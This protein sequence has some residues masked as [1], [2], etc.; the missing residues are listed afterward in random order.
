MAHEIEFRSGKYSFVENGKHELSWHN[1]GTVYDRP[2][3]A[4]E[5]LIGCRAD[6]VV[7]SRK[8]TSLTEEQLIK[9][10]SG[11]PIIILPEQISDSHRAITRKDTNKILSVASDRYSI[12]QNTKAFEFVDYL[13]TGELGAKASID[14]AGVLMDGKKIFITAKFDEQVKIPGSN[15]DIMDFYL[16]FTNGFDKQSPV[17]C[18]TTPIRVVC[19]NTLNAAFNNNSGR[20]RFRHFGDIESKLQLKEENVKHALRCLNVFDSYKKE[21]MHGIEILGNKN[22]TEEQS[23]NIIKFIYCPEGLKKKLVNNNYNIDTDDFS[24]VYRNIV[25]KVKD[26]VNNG[27]GQDIVQKDTGLWLFNGITTSTQ[28]KLNFKSETKKFESLTE[29]KSYD[30]LNEAYKLI[31][32]A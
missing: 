31:L 29:G 12:L 25:N 3:T 15:N 2:L 26:S 23:Y 17:C 24:S 1:L 20:I 28:N 22:L 13:T 30:F 8:L 21:F 19:N 18:M 5:A 16:V 14:A 32:A 6:Y 10:N 4:T 27:I 11:E 9:V 7:E